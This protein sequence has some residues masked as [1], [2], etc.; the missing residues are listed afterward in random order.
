MTIPKDN[1]I[2]DGLGVVTVPWLRFFQRLTRQGPAAASVTLTG[3][4]FTKS[5]GTNGMLTVS[6]GTVSAIDYRRG[7]TGSFAS[8]GTTSGPIPVKALDA[9][10]ITYTVAPTVTFYSD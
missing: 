9:V 4:P 8:I 7:T 1:R 5:F 3:S 2:T 10:R 6:G